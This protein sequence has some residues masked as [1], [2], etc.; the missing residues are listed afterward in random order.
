MTALL[1]G[2][3]GLVGRALAAQWTNAEPLH[4]LVRRPLPAPDAA[5]PAHR[6][7]VVDFA[8][9]PPLPA[10]DQAFCCLGTTIKVAGSQAA[11]RAVDFDAVLAFARACR[12]AGVTRFA[13][14]S[15]LGAD[16]K[17]G[18]FYS[19]VKGEAEAALQA[20]GFTTLVVARPSL[21]AGDRAA[22]GQ[23]LR[24]GERLA[25]AVTAPLSR[26][27]PKAWRPI[28]AERVARA[29]V[30]ALAQAQPGVRVLGSGEMQQLGG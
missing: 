6:V 4:L 19:R 12:R 5:H 3:T 30:R 11:F 13:A 1:A 14:V 2:A 7:H 22:L 25:L 21:L 15:A 17:S 20:L 24:P 26:L 10:A 29:L 8:A 18:N 9:L 23:P 28:E 16:A 27:I